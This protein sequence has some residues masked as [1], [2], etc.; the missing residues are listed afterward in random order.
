MGW[1]LKEKDIKRY[2][3]FDAFVPLTELQKLATDPMAVDRHAFLP[4][5]HYSKSWQPFRRAIDRPKKKNRP[6]R[7][8]SRCD[9][10]VYSYYRHLL[11]QLYEK[12]LAR[13]EIQSCPIAYRKLQ[14]ANGTGGMCNIDFAAQAFEDIKERGLCCAV[15][16]D[17]SGYFDSIDHSRGLPPV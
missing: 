14:R 3:H 5:L 8:A 6:I 11:S 17:I 9:S 1:P 13:L 10:A 7:Y 4:F 2:P 15:T 12:E 16:L